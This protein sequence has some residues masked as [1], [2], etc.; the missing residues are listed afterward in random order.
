[1]TSPTDALVLSRRASDRLAALTPAD[2]TMSPDT[3]EDIERSWADNT[4]RAYDGDLATFR[5]WCAEV[6]RC[7]LPTTAQTLG[8]YAK[9]RIGLGRAPRSVER[10]LSAIRTEH[11]RNDLPLPDLVYADRVLATCRKN[12]AKAGVA[13]R[14]AVAA[15]ADLLKAAVAGCDPDTLAGRRDRALI[16]CGFAIFA[17]RSELVALDIADIRYVPQGLTVTI[18][19]SKTDQRGAGQTVP[20]RPGQ[21]DFS[22]VAMMR[23]WTDT[24]A[25]RG[26]TGGALWRPVDR[27]GRLAGEPGFAGRVPPGCRLNDRAVWTILRRAALRAAQDAR[28]LSPHSLRRGAATEYRRAGGDLLAIARRGRWKDGSP[29]L[30]RYIEEADLFAGDDPMESVF[31]DDVASPHMRG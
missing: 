13:D 29:V 26:V 17:R 6:G 30:L 7:D 28:G 27:N 12:R 10:A 15:A 23:T 25:D 19:Y 24:L 20:V 11:R 3:I 22:P 5:T 21:P 18:R 14:Q 9:H 1:V 31:A 2:Y 8:E 16:L 4:R